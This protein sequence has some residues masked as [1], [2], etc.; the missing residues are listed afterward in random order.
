MRKLEND[1]SLVEGAA[2]ESLR[3]DVPVQRAER[4]AA[5][6]IEPRGRHI[7]EGQRVFFVIG[8]P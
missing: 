7:R 8:W 4:R 2:E 5:E 3:Y 1:P 6:D